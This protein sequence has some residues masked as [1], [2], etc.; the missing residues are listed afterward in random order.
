MNALTQTGPLSVKSSFGGRKVVDADTHF[1]EPFDL[2]TKR[3]PSKYK[4]KVPQVVEVNGQLRWMIDET[5]SIGYGASS[6]SAIRKDGS[7][8]ELGG[9]SGIPFAEALPACFDA[10]ARVAVMD[11]CGVTAQ[12]AYPN[13]LGFGSTSANKVDPAIRAISMQIYN[14]AMA[15]FQEESGRRIFPMAL[16]PWWDCKAMVEETRRA[17]EMGLRG[18]TTNPEPFEHVDADGKP[19]PDLGH[20]HWDPFW[21]VCQSLDMPVN[22]HIGASAA[23][24]DWGASKGWPSAPPFVR[25]AVGGTL[26]FL[27]NA[28]TMG[29]IVFSGLLDRY[30]KLKFV[31]VESG[32]GWIPFVMETWDYQITQSSFKLQRAPSEYVRHNFHT[33]FWYERENLCRDIKK[34][35]VDNVMFET[36]FPHPGGLWPISIDVASAF[37]GLEEAEIAKVLSGNAVR[38][39]NLPI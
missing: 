39:Y 13:L 18:V 17:H 24:I 1:S 7:R 3:A 5:H 28:S 26:L 31:S 16:V 14:D 29:N 37:A 27:S 2:W 15:E 38:V 19:L 9:T 11:A 12:I 4:A 35:G 32:L 21:E 23:S 30:P 22:F 34:V 20:R 8:A 25:T 33:M 36:D 10:K 6:S